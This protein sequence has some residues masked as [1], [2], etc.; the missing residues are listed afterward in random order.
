[1]QRDFCARF[2]IAVRKVRDHGVQ[3]PP[4]Y[5]GFLFIMSLQLNMEE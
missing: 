3:L 4:E 2:E 5:L 1:M